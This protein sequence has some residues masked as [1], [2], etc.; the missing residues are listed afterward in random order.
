VLWKSIDQGV[1][2]EGGVNGAAGLSRA[3][4]WI[5]SRMQSGQIGVYMVLFVVGAVYVLGMVA[6]R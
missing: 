6:W 3:L 4:G 2:D 5:G 1:I